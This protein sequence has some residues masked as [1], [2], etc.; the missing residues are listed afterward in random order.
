MCLMVEWDLRDT[1]SIAKEF[2][3][4]WKVDANACAKKASARIGSKWG[5]LRD[6][7]HRET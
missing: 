1:D 2:D 4:S 3:G 7:A 6:S 5:P